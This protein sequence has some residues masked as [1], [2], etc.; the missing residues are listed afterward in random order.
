MEANCLNIKIDTRYF[1][2]DAEDFL[3]NINYHS[4]IEHLRKEC[5]TTLDKQ[6]G[7]IVGIED[8][9]SFLTITI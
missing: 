6:K 3:E 8:S 7:I 9:D 5:L 2:K 1:S 4:N